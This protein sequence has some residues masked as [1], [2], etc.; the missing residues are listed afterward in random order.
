MEFNDRPLGRGV[1]LVAQSH[2]LIAARDSCSSEED[3]ERRER[4]HELIG[5]MTGKV[6]AVFHDA[7]CQ[8]AHDDDF[9]WVVT[10]CVEKA[11][12]DLED[13]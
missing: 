10:A 2:Y 1:S 13:E 3:E 5:G 9:D 7:L 8:I 11:Q 4:I 12:R 6:R